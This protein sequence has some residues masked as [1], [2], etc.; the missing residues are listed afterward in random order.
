MKYAIKQKLILFI[1]WVKVATISAL[2]DS[3]NYQMDS[4]LK[5]IPLNS[6]TLKHTKIDGLQQEKVASFYA[7]TGSNGLP[8]GLVSKFITG[9]Y[10][11][12]EEMKEYESMLF[13]VNRIGF[14]QDASVSLYPLLGVTEHANGNSFIKNATLGTLS[15][16]G[17]SFTK[18]AFGVFFRG[19][20]PYL[21]EKKEIGKNEFYQLRQ[22]YLNIQL[23]KHWTWGDLT[24]SPEITFIQILDFRRGSTQDLFLKTDILADTIT[25]GGR[26]YN[27]STGYNFWGRGLGIAAGFQASLPIKNLGLFT[28]GLH[29]FGLLNIPKLNTQSRGFEWNSG[30]LNPSTE[31]PVQ[32][33]QIQSVEISGTDFKANNWF[34]RQVDTVIARVGIEERQSYGTVL[35]PFRF[36]LAW[37]SQATFFSNGIWRGYRLAV[38]YIHVVGFIPRFSSDL[39][40]A[41]TKNMLLSH[42]ISYGGFDVF[43]LNS[44]V[45]F[46]AG[47]IHGRALQWSIF[48]RG[49]ES[50]V[51]P[52]N[53]HGGGVGVE[54]LYSFLK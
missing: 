7:L 43:D 3:L 10:I 4:L 41:P 12:P 22:R 30:S 25:L 44:S 27:Q 36:N 1:L 26:F 45:S 52:N 28:M 29:D 46:S 13:N 6:N 14:L 11:G 38:N 16:G 47:T 9:G 37:N 50:F 31:K 39:R 2:S 19:N 24:V 5:T 8:L 54:L 17:I 48:M 35:S 40:W 15:L 49:I 51:S 53:Y 34:G 20:T 23:N 21:G 42:G 33:V 18:D 32:D